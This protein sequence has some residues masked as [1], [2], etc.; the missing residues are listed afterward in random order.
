MVKDHEEKRQLCPVG[1]L[2]AVQE[3]KRQ[4]SDRGG[5]TISESKGYSGG[6]RGSS[7][8]DSSEFSQ[9]SHSHSS[10]QG[11]FPYQP[12]PQL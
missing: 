5:G 2:L 11:P 9:M 7:F 1:S 4:T 3:R 12:T 8:S 10:S 6:F